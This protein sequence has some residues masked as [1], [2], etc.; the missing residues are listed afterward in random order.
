MTIEDKM[1]LQIVIT[2]RFDV[3]VRRAH[4]TGSMLFFF[5]SDNRYVII[6]STLE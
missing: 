1:W 3:L 6:D 4:Q 5:A 2:F